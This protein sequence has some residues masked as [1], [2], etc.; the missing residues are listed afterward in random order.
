MERAPAGITIP[1][2]RGLRIAANQILAWDL[3][4]GYPYTAMDDSSSRAVL[5]PGCLLTDDSLAYVYMS[6]GVRRRLGDESK[7]CRALL[8]RHVQWIVKFLNYA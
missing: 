5:T 6:S 2:V 3:Q 4:V 1:S 8:H 7:P